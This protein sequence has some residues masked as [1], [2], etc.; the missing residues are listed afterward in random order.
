M[1]DEVISGNP[2]EVARK[3]L[4][5]PFWPE[6]IEAREIYFRTHD[7]CDGDLSKG[8]QVVF[9]DDG[10]AHIRTC[11]EGC[12]F[13]TWGGGGM[14]LRVRNALLLLALAI[15]MDNEEHPQNNL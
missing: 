10:D 12:R 13:R 3:I 8:I 15:N 9:S 1:E 6:S 4:D 2:Q 5:T 14:S 7:D 11:M